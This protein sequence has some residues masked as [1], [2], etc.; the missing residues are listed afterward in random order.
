[1]GVV[2]DIGTITKTRS[3]AKFKLIMID[4]ACDVYDR[5]I[6]INIIHSFQLQSNGM[7][8]SQLVG[9]PRVVL[10]EIGMLVR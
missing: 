9:T 4:G 6:T 8:N 5:L 3:D 2:T 1:M 10:I 7:P